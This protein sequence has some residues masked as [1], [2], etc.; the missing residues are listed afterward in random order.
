MLANPAQVVCDDSTRPAPPPAKSP[1]LSLEA[2]LQRV[3]IIESYWARPASAQISK[4][5]RTARP[6]D[7]PSDSRKERTCAEEN[8]VKAD[9]TS[10]S[11]HNDFQA[12]PIGVAQSNQNS[13]SARLSYLKEVLR[14]RPEPVETNKNM[15]YSHEQSAFVPR[16]RHRH[17]RTKRLRL[18]K[19]ADV[20]PIVPPSVKWDE[21]STVHSGND[22]SILT[23][24]TA[25]QSSRQSISTSSLPISE[26]TTE[27]KHLG[28]KFALMDRPI[29]GTW[30]PALRLLQS[31]INDHQVQ[32]QQPSIV[33]SHRPIV[34]SE[35]GTYP[36]VEV[37]GME[38]RRVREKLTRNSV[39]R[40]TNTGSSSLPQLH[41]VSKRSDDE[42]STRYVSHRGGERT[43]QRKKRTP[44]HLN[45]G[46]K[47]RE[48]DD[49]SIFIRE[50]EVSGQDVMNGSQNANSP[51]IQKF[52]AAH[53]LSRP[54]KDRRSPQK[55]FSRNKT[56]ARPAADSTSRGNIKRENGYNEPPKNNSDIKSKGDSEVEAVKGRKH[57]SGS[58]HAGRKSSSQISLHPSPI[59][60]HNNIIHHRPHHLFHNIK[61][62]HHSSCDN[63]VS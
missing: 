51:R 56:N 12:L 58:G 4:E 41:H 16:K 25:D 50:G 11:E 8:F 10:T 5:D 6:T 42:A 45:T 40:Y 47:S 34:N 26:D 37:P 62:I 61:S 20:M 39:A 22:S 55:S 24:K 54:D 59:P 14:E 23:V 15:V 27:A 43:W 57:Q 28:R 2:M 31:A 36:K 60:R 49:A 35:Q 32:M 3:A 38:L 46:P 19:T 17:P 53:L 63:C 18:P 48:A 29:E 7:V 44:R 1:G 21:P 9:Q 30:S 52:V 33:M 13:H